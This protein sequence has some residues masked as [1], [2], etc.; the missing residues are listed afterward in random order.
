MK[1]FERNQTPIFNLGRS[2]NCV[3]TGMVEQM[4]GWDESDRASVN[5]GVEQDCKAFTQECKENADSEVC[6]A[7]REKFNSK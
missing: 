1:L 6:I 2:I 3:E 5:V 7:L 4:K